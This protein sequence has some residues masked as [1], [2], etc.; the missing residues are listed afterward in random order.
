M[1]RCILVGT[2]ETTTITGTPGDDRLEGDGN[3]LTGTA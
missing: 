2:P 1:R 3:S